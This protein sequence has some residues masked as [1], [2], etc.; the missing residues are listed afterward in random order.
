MCVT[1]KLFCYGKALY[2]TANHCVARQSIVFYGKY[3]CVLVTS[4]VSTS[5]ALDIIRL[6][7]PSHGWLLN[8]MKFTTNKTNFTTN[9]IKKST[10]VTTPGTFGAGRFTEVILSKNDVKFQHN[11]LT[12]DLLILG[13]PSVDSC[14][15]SVNSYA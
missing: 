13:K 5:L 1:V 2:G 12:D 4:R 7:V 15:E 6:Q 9:H 10:K 8:L 14:Y 11:F 3:L